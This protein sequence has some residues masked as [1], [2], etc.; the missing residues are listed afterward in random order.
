[1]STS[2]ALVVK[3]STDFGQFKK[4]PTNRVENSTHIK[5]LV[6]AINKNPDLTKLNF[7][8]V[9]ESYQVVDG[10]HRLAAHRAL[11]D[12]G[13]IY[14]IWY[15]TRSGLTIKDAQEYNAGAKPWRPKEYADVFAESGDKNYELYLEF[16]NRTGLNHDI[17]VRYLALDSDFTLDTFRNGGFKAQNYTQTQRLAE[18]LEDTGEY[19]DQWQHRSYAIGFLMVARSNDYDHQRM[20]EQLDL[21]GKSLQTVPLKNVDIARQLQRIYNKL[22]TDKVIL[23]A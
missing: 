7:I 20:L 16:V 23:L 4:L 1:M 3:S 10:Q 2:Y 14:P 19:F 9:N 22:R 18:R 13:E 6:R 21:H 5:R 12:C 17:A 11:A 8:T 15:A